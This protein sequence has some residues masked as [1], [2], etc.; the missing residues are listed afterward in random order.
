MQNNAE[1]ASLSTINFG[2]ATK[3][4]RRDLSVLRILTPIMAANEQDGFKITASGVYSGTKTYN[5]CEAFNLVCSDSS[6][7]EVK[8]QSGWIQIELPNVDFYNHLKIG[9]TFSNEE[10]ESFVLS[11]SNDGENYDELLN[12]GE[13]VWNHKELK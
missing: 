5:P 13:L 9:G 7:W 1:Y 12:S 10:P 8:S 4:Y 11:A 3:Q 6:S 2:T